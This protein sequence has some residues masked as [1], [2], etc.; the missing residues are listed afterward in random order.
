MDER[1]Q[2][3]GALAAM[4]A[5]LAG[6]QLRAGDPD[7]RARL[8][9]VQAWQARRLAAEYA[10]Q[11]SLPR[12]RAAVDFFLGEVYGTRDFAERDAQFARAVQRMRTMMPLA[13][14]QA[15][16]DAVELQAVTTELDLAVAAQLTPGLVTLEAAH[17]APAYRLAGRQPERHR[18]IALAVSLGHRLEHLTAHPG[19]AL[20]LRFAAAPARLAGFGALQCFIERGYAAFRQLGPEA[21]AFLATIEQREEA[22]RESM[23]NAAVA[24]AAAARAGGLS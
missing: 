1:Q 11:R 19:I 13:A 12:R 10:D 20:L 22:F 18:Q 14:L 17:Y 4:L 21:G 8:A 15:L 9:A 3:V 16:R 7:L 6:A 24:P 5:R 23:V 2:C